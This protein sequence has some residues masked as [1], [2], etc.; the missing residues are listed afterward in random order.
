MRRTRPYTSDFKSIDPFPSFV[1][2]IDTAATAHFPFVASTTATADP[3]S[4]R[5]GD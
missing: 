2:L 4:A 5:W 3:L 1:I